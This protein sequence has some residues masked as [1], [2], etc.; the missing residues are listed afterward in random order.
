MFTTQSF[1]W[2]G[3]NLCFVLVFDVVVILIMWSMNNDC[4]KKN[5][6]IRNP[7]W[8]QQNIY[9]LCMRYFTLLKLQLVT[10]WS[11]K[12]KIIHIVHYTQVVMLH[13]TASKFCVKIVAVQF[14]CVVTC[15]PTFQWIKA[16]LLFLSLYSI[17][18]IILYELRVIS[19][20][21]IGNGLYE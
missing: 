16:V 12:P 7:K 2:T 15:C 1:S 17:V 14:E 4:T 20:L 18:R 5:V 21:Y 6:N 8:T 19:S 11:I 10:M 9:I 13:H 3:K